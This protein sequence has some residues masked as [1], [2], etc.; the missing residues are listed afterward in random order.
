M[1]GRMLPNH[2][3]P[4][5][6]RATALVAVLALIGC[7][8]GSS[9]ATG[10]TNAELT[11]LHKDAAGGGHGDDGDADDD[12]AGDV[13]GASADAATPDADLDAP[14]DTA[15]SDS[16]TPS[17]AG[18]TDAGDGA[19]PCGV[20]DPYTCDQLTQKC[21]QNPSCSS[22]QQLSQACA[23]APCDDAGHRCH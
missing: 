6:A 17:D 2:A 1:A 15:T 4:S 11:P 16:A 5:L 12:D 19:C 7:S 22:C 20:V 10:F 21:A 9:P 23:C 3:L 18:A 14:T 8:A 13:D